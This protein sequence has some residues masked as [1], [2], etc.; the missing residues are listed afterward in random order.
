MFV[1]AMYLYVFY[2]LFYEMDVSKDMS[3]EK[4]SEERYP[5]LNEEEDIRIDEIRD[6]HWM[7]V[8]E[9]GENTKRIHG[10]GWGV[11]VKEKE[12][13]MKREFLM[14]VPHTKGGEQLFGI[15]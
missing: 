6:E 3:E 14:S 1:K 13:L 5:Y 15:V 11:Y 9:E 10:L 4:V 8:S 2:C 12:E 7:D